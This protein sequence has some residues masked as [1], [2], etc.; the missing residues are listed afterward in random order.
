MCEDL[1]QTALDG[2]ISCG[3]IGD[4]IR[5]SNIGSENR[6]HRDAPHMIL[7][8]GGQN[9]EESSSNNMF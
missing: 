6:V 1:S 8:L 9:H 3:Y 4:Q 7:G 5:R 2:L